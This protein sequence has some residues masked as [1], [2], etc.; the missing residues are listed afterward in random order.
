M[1]EDVARALLGLLP[2]DSAYG[3]VKTP[4]EPR[5]QT[6]DGKTFD[7][8]LAEAFDTVQ[9]LRNAGGGFGLNINQPAFDDWALNGPLSLNVDDRRL[10]HTVRQKTQDRMRPLGK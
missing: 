3:L 6:I 2:P 1:S 10:E 4:R 8:A 5:V 9:H 7:Q